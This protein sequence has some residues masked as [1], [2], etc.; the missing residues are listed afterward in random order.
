MGLSHRKAKLCMCTP[1]CLKCLISF[2]AV[3]GRDRVPNHRKTVLTMQ[4]ALSQGGPTSTNSERLKKSR[5]KG[6][7]RQFVLLTELKQFYLC[8]SLLNP[9]YFIIF[10]F[11]QLY[12]VH[13][14]ADL[15]GAGLSCRGEECN[16][17]NLLTSL[18]LADLA[19]KRPL[20]SAVV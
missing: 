20:S 7:P 19:Y 13:S 9:R 4:P 17:R 11:H 14:C 6:S 15:G 8:G 5:K 18:S 1:F 10:V 2:H 12:C 3:H 16:Q